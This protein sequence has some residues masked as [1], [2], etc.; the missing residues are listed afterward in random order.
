MSE[1]HFQADSP[2]TAAAVPGSTGTIQ[3]GDRIRITGWLDGA[4]IVVKVREVDGATITLDTF[5]VPDP[6][7]MAR[8]RSSVDRAVAEKEREP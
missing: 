2:T 8:I 5:D 6:E 7:T 1:H 3:A 4:D